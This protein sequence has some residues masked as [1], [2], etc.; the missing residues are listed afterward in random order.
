M[1]MNFLLVHTFVLQSV[2][3]ASRREPVWLQGFQKNF[4]WPSLLSRSHKAS[5]KALNQIDGNLL[6]MQTL[7]R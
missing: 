1:K 6:L 3:E 7:A 4:L 5:H 2:H